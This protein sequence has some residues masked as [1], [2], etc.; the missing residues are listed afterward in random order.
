MGAWNTPFALN[1]PVSR[2]V[3]RG[4]IGKYVATV[5]ATVEH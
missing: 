5:M 4:D 1:R 2:G 3:R